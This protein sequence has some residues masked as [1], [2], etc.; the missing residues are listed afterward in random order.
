[1]TTL[2]RQHHARSEEQENMDST[3]QL[4][5][6]KLGEEEYCID[7]HNIQEINKRMHI[8]RVPKNQPFVKGVINL[9]GKVICVI[10]L[11]KRFGLPDNFDND[12]RIMVIDLAHETMGFVVDSVT[13]VIRIPV[14][15]VDPTPPLIGHISNEYLL[16]VGKTDKR[17]LIIID[18]NRVV[19]F[20]TRVAATMRASLNAR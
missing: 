6:F 12:T 4:V 2:E 8:T 9:R 5:G 17:L 20:K 19:G 14:N 3:L 1:M 10:D 18:L 15:R 11:R 13:E 7:I 16:G